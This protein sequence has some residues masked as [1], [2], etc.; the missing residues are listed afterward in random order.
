M[1][2]MVG[3]AFENGVEV[4]QLGNP[5]KIISLTDEDTS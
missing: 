3:T 5:G 4:G 1:T 2:S